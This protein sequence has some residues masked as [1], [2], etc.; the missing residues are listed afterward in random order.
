MKN[1]ML[2]SYLVLKSIW[3]FLQRKHYYRKIFLKAGKKTR[4]KE[5][6]IDWEEVRAEVKP[7]NLCRGR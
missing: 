4:V 1:R 3:G 6:Y 7:S 2:L 5:S